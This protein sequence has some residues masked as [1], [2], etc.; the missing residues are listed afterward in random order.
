MALGLLAAACRSGSS[1]GGSATGT[2]ASAAPPALVDLPPVPDT[3][4]AAP[5]GLLP[6]VLYTLK[7]AH[8]GLVLTWRE[9]T[10]C[11]TIEVER[12]DALQPYPSQAGPPVVA[13][14]TRGAAPAPARFAVPAG[15]L[16]YL[17]TTATRDYPYT[18]HARCRRAG[19]AS[20]WSNEL[21]TNP[22]KP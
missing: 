21:A 15:T 12:Q 8:P 2:T 19:V 1:K 5:L 9:P 17:D 16:S 20:G 6:P 4:G 11:E 22:A 14:V 10:L 18:Y 3:S 13:S 7:P